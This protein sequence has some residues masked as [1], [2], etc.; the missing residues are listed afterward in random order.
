MKN[1][2]PLTLKEVQNLSFFLSN[3]RQ[4]GH[5][6]DEILNLID[7]NENTEVIRI[8]GE[9]KKVI[10]KINGNI[11]EG[12]QI[13]GRPYEDFSKLLKELE[14]KSSFLTKED[15]ETLQKV[16]EKLLDSLEL[17]LQLNREDTVLQLPLMM[18]EYLKNLQI[19]VMRDKK[20]SKKINPKDMSILLNFDTNN[21]GNVN[22]YVA[23]NYKNIVMKMGL[24]NE[25]DRNLIEKYSA[26]L[27][28]HLEELGYDL[29]DLSFRISDDNHILSMADEMEK[30]NPKI[31]RLLDV[32]I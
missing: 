3:Q 1:A 22:I 15:K 10:S 26:E 11:K 8:A 29:K 21:M 32:R 16:G 6:L 7:K 23:V 13:E 2:M 20:G 18:S 25:E 12:R 5:Q 27:G 19:Y 17:Q 14:S 24:A 4:I 30:K 9:L 28:K 31:K